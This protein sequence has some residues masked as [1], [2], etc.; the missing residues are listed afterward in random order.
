MKNV[1]NTGE[2]TKKQIKQKT[3]THFALLKEPWNRFSNPK[4]NSSSPIR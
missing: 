1:Y 2:R 3:K 4:C